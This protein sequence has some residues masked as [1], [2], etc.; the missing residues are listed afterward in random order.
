MARGVP[1][2]VARDQLAEAMLA[3]KSVTHIMWVD[4]DSICSS[5]PN[6]N[7]AL[8]MLWQC[9]Q[10]IVSGLYRAK[11]KDGFNY[12][13]WMDAHLPE[14]KLGFLPI[15][16]FTGNWL[17][18]DTVG[19]G[20]V[21]IQRKVYE[22]IPRPWHPW[23]T[24]APCV[25][26]GSQEL[27]GTNVEDL[28]QGQTIISGHGGYSSVDKKFS[29]I[30]D[31]EL[32]KITP[33]DHRVP[34]SVTPN[35]RILTLQGVDTVKLNYRKK[36]DLQ[37]AKEMGRSI[38]PDL[39]TATE[40]FKSATELTKGDFIALTPLKHH[41]Q[42]RLPTFCDNEYQ[43]GRLFGFY[44]A[45][46]STEPKRGRVR[47][48]FGKSEKELNL[49]YQAQRDMLHFFGKA[50]RVTRGDHSWQLCIGSKELSNHFAQ[51]FNLGAGGKT[52]PIWL[53]CGSDE[54]VRGYLQGLW[55]GD[56]YVTY[57]GYHRPCFGLNVKSKQVALTTFALLLRFGI[58]PSLRQ[59]KQSAK[60]F[61]H[62]NNIYVVKVAKDI[63]KMSELL[64]REEQVKS[65]GLHSLPFFF[66]D[67]LWV[68]I[69]SVE[70]VNYKG[71]VHDIQADLDK[72]YSLEGVAVHNSEDFNFCIAARKAG[73]FINVFTDV[74]L[75]HLGEMGVNLDGTITVLEV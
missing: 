30:H 29:L 18:V 38:Y 3:D 36:S 33:T 44:I 13:M 65:K 73:F 12:A 20:F 4:S 10:P 57:T 75:R 31:G 41:V 17:Q 49:A 58:R 51:W 47:F 11:Q 62:G 19:M 43:L 32:V 7:D 69:D 2:N 5:P 35:H 24:Q 42:V 39:T 34:I 66:N 48:S 68:P 70:R 27:L 46:G 9:N 61:G 23:P 26:T 56:G 74:K 53:A 67:K 16:S 45:E 6:P 54:L 50:G 28:K 40:V 21:L 37:K 72:T 8:Q 25:P 52:I 59:Y 64:G 22:T 60:A 63:D 71:F 55:E 14:G 15:Q 1:L